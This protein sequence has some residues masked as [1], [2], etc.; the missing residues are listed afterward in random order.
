MQKQQKEYRSLHRFR[1][2]SNQPNWEELHYEARHAGLIREEKV[3]RFRQVNH[4]T[5]TTVEHTFYSL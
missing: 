4:Q 2:K 1:E 5:V 3:K